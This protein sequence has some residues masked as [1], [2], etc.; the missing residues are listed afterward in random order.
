VRRSENWKT[1]YV[2]GVFT[3]KEYDRDLW[4]KFCSCR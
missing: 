1:L 3:H 4:K 2:V